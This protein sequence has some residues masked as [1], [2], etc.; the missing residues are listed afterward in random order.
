MKN[1]FIFIYLFT[2]ARV[3][4]KNTCLIILFVFLFNYIKN[5]KNM[6]MRKFS[7]FVYSLALESGIKNILIWIYFIA[8]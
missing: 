1:K 4:N 3:K 8:T 7:S 6:W 2:N 5:K